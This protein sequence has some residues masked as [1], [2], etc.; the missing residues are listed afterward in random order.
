MALIPRMPP[1]MFST[2]ENLSDLR[3]P[4]GEGFYL[5]VSNNSLGMLSFL[6]E[7]STTQSGEPCHTSFLSCACLP[8]ITSCKVSFRDYPRN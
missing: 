4:S 5:N 1:I 6:H 7:F 3:D 8:G 2:L